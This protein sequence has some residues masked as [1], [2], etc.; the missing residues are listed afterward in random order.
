[1]HAN[2]VTI[3]ADYTVDTARAPRGVSGHQRALYLTLSADQRRAYRY[4]Y[5]VCGRLAMHCYEIVTAG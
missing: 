1:M 5:D 2:A 3:P 4:N